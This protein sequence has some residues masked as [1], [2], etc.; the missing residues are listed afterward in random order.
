MQV[1]LPGQFKRLLELARVVCKRA[2]PGSGLGPPAIADYP[3]GLP[4]IRAWFAK[5]EESCRYVTRSRSDLH[6]WLS[7]R[8]GRASPVHYL[9]FGVY[10]G[11]T[12]LGGAEIT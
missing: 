9:E 12:S 10:R 5:H 2:I 11:E 3:I 7:E 6:R 8:L 4:R 1:S